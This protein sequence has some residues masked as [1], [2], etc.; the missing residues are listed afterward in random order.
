MSP[1]LRT[2]VAADLTL[3][4]NTHTH[5]QTLGSFCDVGAVRSGSTPSP[6]CPDESNAMYILDTLPKLCTLVGE[7]RRGTNAGWLGQN[8]ITII[9]IIFE[10]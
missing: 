9:I 6:V 2:D 5:T 1:G 4:T 8:S 10:W 7:N 3:P